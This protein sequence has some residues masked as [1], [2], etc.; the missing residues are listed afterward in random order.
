[1][2]TTVI[3]PAHHQR[4]DLQRQLGDQHDRG[5]D[6]HRRLQ[7]RR[8]RPSTRA[9]P[10]G[11]SAS[12]PTSTT[13]PTA[14]HPFP[15]RA[16]PQAGTDRPS[17]SSRV[18]GISQETCRDFG[19]AQYG[20]SGAL[21]AAETAHIQGVDLYNDG[22]SNAL[23]RLTSALEFNAK[24]LLANSSTVPSYVCGGTV[25]LQVYPTDEIGYNEYHN[26]IGLDL[27]LTL[28]YLQTSYP[29][30]RQPDRVPHHGL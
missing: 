27:P 17:T 7:R 15:L 24:Y 9:S 21:D 18:D 29:S 11:S 3:L 2:L 8:R 13:T 26:R 10:T 5:H 22:P 14:L 19:H 30:A 6:R 23:L 25:T 20:I 28:Q 16:A 1:M 4:L 12:R